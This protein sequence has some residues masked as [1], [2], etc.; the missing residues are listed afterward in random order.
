MALTIVGF[1]N[2]LCASNLAFQM[3][4]M[5][6][7]LKVSLLVREMTVTLRVGA[8]TFERHR[9]NVRAGLTV[10]EGVL[11][12]RFMSEAQVFKRIQLD[13]CLWPSIE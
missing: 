8:A 2:L 9:E 5:F 1:G 10:G 7:L 4:D 11:C 3:I 13:P 6:D 12:P